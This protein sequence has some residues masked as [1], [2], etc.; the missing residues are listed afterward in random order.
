MTFRLAQ[1]LPAAALLF[2]FACSAAGKD[3]DTSSDTDANANANAEADADADTDTDTD[4]DTD[5][6]ADADTDTDTDTDTDNGGGSSYGPNNGWPHAAAGDV[7][8]DLAG[9]GWYAGDTAYNFTLKDQNGDDVE[10]YQFYGMLV[11]LDVF[12]VWCGPCNELAPDGEE[13]WQALADRGVVYLA[14][15]L[16]DVNGNPPT[17]ETAQQWAETHG[18]T[19]PIVA[20]PDMS[21]EQYVS[22]GGG[23]PS[24]PVIGP[25]MTI[26]TNDLFPPTV[27]DV[28]AL[29]DEQGM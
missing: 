1:F 25:D 21:Q 19:H 10:L 13:V 3:E 18:L 6:D 12:A 4:A 28:G 24:F 8:T 20:D 5:A 27:V 11:V 29:L 26:L 23:Y 7:P 17:V 9:T 14:V 22:I 15:T 16:E 2:T